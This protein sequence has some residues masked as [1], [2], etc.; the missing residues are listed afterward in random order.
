MGGC[1]MSLFERFQSFFILLAVALGLYFGRFPGISD[2]AAAFITPFL[3]AMLY[4]VFLQIPLNN[5]RQALTDFK[6]TGCYNF[7]TSGRS[8]VW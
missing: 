1:S 6:F 3:M 5:L 4:S 8:A 7:F 2:N